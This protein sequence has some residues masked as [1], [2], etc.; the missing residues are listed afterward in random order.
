MPPR[1][2][3]ACKEPHDGDGL[4]CTAC[5]NRPRGGTVVTRTAASSPAPPEPRRLDDGV[6]E[7]VIPWS[8]L[9]E[10]NKNTGVAGAENR[11]KRRQFKQGVARFR[12]LV[13]EQHAG[14]ASS[15][16]VAVEVRLYVPDNRVRDAPNLWKAI[17]DG[18]KELVITDDRWQVMRRHGMDVVGVDQDRPRAEITVR[19]IVAADG[20][21]G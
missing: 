3:T 5:Q 21:E 20:S 15:G 16:P 10:D 2:C 14:P 8:G 7:L 6:L 9:V 11:E 4:Q 13:R 1:I 19:E 12:Q 18:L 17:G